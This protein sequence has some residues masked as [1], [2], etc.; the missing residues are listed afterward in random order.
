MG[1][2]N[3]LVEYLLRLRLLVLLLAIKPTINLL[4]KRTYI[5][6]KISKLSPM[7]YHLGIERNHKLF[8]V[9]LKWDLLIRN[10]LNKKEQMDN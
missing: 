10:T 7:K 8:F 6:E 9:D 4:E 5:L 2:N 1:E 3:R